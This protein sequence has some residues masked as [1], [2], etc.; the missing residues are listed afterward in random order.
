MT[1]VTIIVSL[2]NKCRF[3]SETIQSV[4]AQT[5]KNWSLYIVDN[6]ST[7]GGDCVAKDHESEDARVRLLSYTDTKGPGATRNFGLRYA[8]GEWVLF[9]DA[10][11][12]IEPDHLTNLLA[13]AKENPEAP[14]IAGHWQEF[15]DEHPEM[16]ILRQPFCIGQDNA[17]LK[18]A[19]IA[20]APWAVHAVIV[21]RDILREK[22]CWPED[23]DRQLGED[24]HFWFRLVMNFPVAYSQ[25]QGALYRTHTPNRRNQISLIERWYRG[26]DAAVEANVDY[27]SKTGR[28]PDAGQC[29]S[30]VRLY[31]ELHWQARCRKDRAVSG[32]A[33]SKAE[34]WFDLRL[35][36]SDVL[37]KTDR[38]RK[39]LGIRLYTMLRYNLTGTPAHWK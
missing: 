7:D 5:F 17:F 20:F 25:S 10:D 33:L 2:F 1:N 37:S 39:L 12:L 30:L 15:T 9:L 26:I 34:Q 4:R 29:D 24:I 32:D 31:S 11:D 8:L 27:L 28:N 22:F 36:A 14:I 6:G 23:L 35:K 13:C 38:L 21:R 19:C 3:I 18:S 16:R